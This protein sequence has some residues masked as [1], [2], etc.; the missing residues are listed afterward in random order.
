MKRMKPKFPPLPL[1]MACGLVLT[2]IAP[3][4]MAAAPTMTDDCSGYTWD[5]SRERAL[6]S[7]QATAVTAATSA[8]PAPALEP[9]RLYAVT[10]AD[11]QQVAYPVAPQKKGHAGGTH[12]GLLRLHVPSAGQYRVALSD[13]AWIDVVAGHEPVPSAAFAGAHGCT[14]PRKIVQ[15][16]LPAGR[17]LVLQLNGADERILV[18][19]TPAPT[20][21]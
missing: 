2:G 6:F 5:V 9:G 11:Q 3:G 13:A 20:A 8:A 10:L 1:V 17:D 21:P 12:G 15:F 4:V 14:A 16:S 19:I 7:T 18:S